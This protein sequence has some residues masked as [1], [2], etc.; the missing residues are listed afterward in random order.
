MDYDILTELFYGNISPIGKTFEKDSKY[1]AFSAIAAENENLLSA[2]LKGDEEDHLFSQLMNV[3]SEILE[4]T[5]R[6]R[7][8]EGFRLGAKIILDTFVLP[9]RSVLRDIT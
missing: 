4:F 9:G 1:A 6:E 7:F 3:Q 2:F 8:L 5:E